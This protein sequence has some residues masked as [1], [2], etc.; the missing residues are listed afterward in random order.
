MKKWGVWSP[1]NSEI[2]EEYEL[3]EDYLH[4]DNALE[5]VIENQ[6][7]DVKN[8]V[9]SEELKRWLGTEHL[10]WM[11]LSTVAR[12]DRYELRS[13]IQRKV[14][15]E[16]CSDSVPESVLVDIASEVSRLLESRPLEKLCSID[17]DWDWVHKLV[18]VVRAGRKI[19]L[20]MSIPDSASSLAAD[21]QE[22]LLEI[23][24]ARQ[25]G[26]PFTLMFSSPN[27]ALE[28]PPESGPLHS[29][30]AEWLTEYLCKYTDLFKLGVCIECGAFFSR[31]RTDRLYCFKSC[32]NR[33]AYRRK[34]VFDSG[35]LK[36]VKIDP[37][38]PDKLKSD[39]W[40]YHPRL[41]LGL[42][43]DVAFSKRRIVSEHENGAMGASS[44][45][46]G[47]SAK[48]Y[49]KQ[50]NASNTNNPVVKWEETVNP[51]SVRLR[52]LFPYGERNFHFSDLF[53]R[54]KG[55]KMMPTF[56]SAKDVEAVANLL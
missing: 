49:V 32:Q 9:K 50:L 5:Y 16:R 3:P 2:D 11:V 37:Q 52:V 40:F 47:V 23:D 25:E 6:W 21:I 20:R 38:A 15:P 19:L 27:F 31:E 45:S 30:V 55:E 42:I 39:L 24:R 44:L 35:L 28:R 41:A 17:G 1:L 8:R 51:E 53:P 36:Q 43:E 18:Q 13:V 7:A 56:Y 33:A 48:D 22:P 12:L 46:E 10:S 4:E 29:R 34:K 54:N 26:T 14:A